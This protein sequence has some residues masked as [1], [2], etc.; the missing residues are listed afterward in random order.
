MREAGREYALG[1]PC[2]HRLFLEHLLSA[3]LSPTRPL[4]TL[5]GLHWLEE[6]GL[7]LREL[8]AEDPEWLAPTPGVWRGPTPWIL[9]SDKG[10][11]ATITRVT[12]SSPTRHR[13]QRAS[14]LTA[15]FTLQGS[16][17]RSR[18]LWVLVYT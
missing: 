14:L 16:L 9:Q 13:S 15:L 10:C 7:V 4:L 2:C 6:G 18:T 5:L 3:N 11:L 8:R 1:R 17:R 12:F